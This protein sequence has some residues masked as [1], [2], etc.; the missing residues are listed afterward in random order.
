MPIFITG[1]SVLASLLSACIVFL[2]MPVAAVLMNFPS[3]K[4]FCIIVLGAVLLLT[5][6]T[7]ECNI[8][9]SF[10][11]FRQFEMALRAKVSN[12]NTEYLMKIQT[13]EMRHMIG[14]Y[15]WCEK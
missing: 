6:T 3:I 5:L 1:H 14:T 15:Q 9:S 7:Y 8:Y 12:E 2:I 10:T 4:F 13:E 11:S